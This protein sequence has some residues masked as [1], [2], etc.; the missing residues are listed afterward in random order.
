M[1]NLLFQHSNQLSQ[2]FYE[3]HMV[4]KCHETFEKV[5]WSAEKADLP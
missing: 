4:R 5:D 2:E 3:V 1:L